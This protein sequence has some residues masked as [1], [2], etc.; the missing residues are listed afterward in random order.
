MKPATVVLKQQTKTLGAQLSVVVP[1]TT[2]EL[3]K[4]ALSKAAELAASLE[5]KIT[6][7]DVHIVPYPLSLTEPDVC[8]EHLNRGLQAVAAAS[9]VPVEVKLIFARDKDVIERYMPKDSIGVIA[10]KKHWWRTAEEKLARSL[11]AAGHS[12]ALVKV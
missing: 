2:D 11:S 5:A 9:P 6:L 3:T 10:T 7:L 12:V 4:T 1:Y 8:W